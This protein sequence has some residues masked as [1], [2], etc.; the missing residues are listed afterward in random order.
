VTE[1]E[2]RAKVDVVLNKAPGNR[3]KWQ[4][5]LKKVLADFDQI[6]DSRRQYME[7]CC[8]TS[9]PPEYLSEQDCYVRL[10]VNN[11]NK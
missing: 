8:L 11:T 6:N 7:D 5:L 2:W 9:I 3:M 1:E 4:N 10:P